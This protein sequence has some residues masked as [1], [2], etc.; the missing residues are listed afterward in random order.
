LQTN[1]IF[2]ILYENTSY[3]FEDKEE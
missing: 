3:K 2:D 1:I